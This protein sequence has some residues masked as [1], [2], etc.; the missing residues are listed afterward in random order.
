MASLRQVGAFNGVL[1][2]ATG[3][4]IGF[5]RDPK[6]FPFLEYTQE[7][8]APNE[9][10]GLF[11]YVT[12]DQDLPTNMVNL[13]EQAWGFNDPMP[14]GKDFIFRA[15]WDSGQTV[16]FAFPY[17]LGDRVKEGWQKGANM[18]LQKYY[19]RIRLGHAM[20]HRANQCVSAVTAFSWPAYN[21]SSL[22]ALR[23]TTGTP[24]YW[25]QSAG[26]ESGPSGTANPKFQIIK[27]TGNRIMRRIDLLTNG[28]LKGEEFSLV[29]GPDV[30]QAIAT[31]GEMVN[32]LKQ[33]QFAKELTVRN[34]KWGIPDK[35]NG[36]NMVVEDT[37]KCTIR[38]NADGTVADVSIAEKAYV[39]PAATVFACSRVGGLDGG[40]GEQN[41]STLQLYTF[42]GPGSAATGSDLRGGVYVKSETD[43][44]NEITKG[45][46]VTEHKALVA[47]PISGFYLTNVLSTN[48]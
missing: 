20:L 22:N 19:D 18:N 41:F 14:A 1:P 27:D 17:F 5:M 34:G 25:D 2:A 29:F 15:K 38:Q 12:L 13:D 11:R 42:N 36:W 44:Y 39:W 10:N 3:Q 8:P 16:R 48:P 35:Y 45:A 33:S 21:T 31:S 6:R 40:Y 47:A 9:G 30:A 24:A 28:A 32:F 43:S 26:N 4:V 23:G 7:V 37:V 46:V